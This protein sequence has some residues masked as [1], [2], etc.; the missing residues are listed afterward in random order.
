MGTYTSGIRRQTKNLVYLSR[1]QQFN[2]DCSYIV[3][4][5]QPQLEIAFPDSS[6][7][8]MEQIELDLLMEGSGNHSNVLFSLLSTACNIQG[9]RFKT[10][11][12]NAVSALLG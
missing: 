6:R 3:G 4:Y 12:G 8:G 5:G 11:N 7:L 10:H 9:F 1:T 2:F